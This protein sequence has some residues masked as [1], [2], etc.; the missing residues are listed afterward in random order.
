VA[1]KINE[2]FEIPGMKFASNNYKFN[3]PY[4]LFVKLIIH[5]TL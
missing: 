3:I 2:L 4:E 5:A 1:L